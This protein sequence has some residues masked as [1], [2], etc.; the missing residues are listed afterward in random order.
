VAEGHTVIGTATTENGAEEISSYLAGSGTGMA[1]NVSSIESI[2]EVMAKIAESYRAPSIVVNNAAITRDNLALRMKDEEWNDVIETNLNSIFHMTKACLKAMVKARWGRM[3]N[4]S[5]VVA[6]TGNPGQI[7]YAAAKAGIIGYT[8]SLA[9]EIA[10]RNITVNAVAPGFIDTDMTR[11][12]PDE[13]K[14][15]LLTTIPMN[16]LGLPQDVAA[17]VAYLASEEAAYVTGQTLNVN[18]GMY[19]N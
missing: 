5:S 2:E 8:K 6:S 12:L 16:R 9:R 18:G 7:N 10:S 17:A 11:G 15:A 14:K 19:M 1:L 3:I 13:Q 4:I